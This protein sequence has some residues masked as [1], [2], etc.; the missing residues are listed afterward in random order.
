M[1]ER[2]GRPPRPRDTIPPLPGKPGPCATTPP[3]FT[4][5]WLLHGFDGFP[6]GSFLRLRDGLLPSALAVRLHAEL[7]QLLAPRTVLEVDAD[8]KKCQPNILAQDRP[9]EGFGGSGL[10]GTAKDHARVQIL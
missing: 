5:C 6:G 3:V 8:L 2:P 7:H 1:A 10:R 4:A 9:P